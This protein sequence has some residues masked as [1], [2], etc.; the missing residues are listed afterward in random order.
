MFLINGLV[1]MMYK[2]WKRSRDKTDVAFCH[3]LIVFSK[4]TFSKKNLLGISPECQTV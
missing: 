2:V 1:D 4:L 3:L